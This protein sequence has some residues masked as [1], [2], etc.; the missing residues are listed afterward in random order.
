M[1][2]LYKKTGDN[3]IP[4]SKLE[5]ETTEFDKIMFTIS[6]GDGM[7]ESDGEYLIDLFGFK[8]EE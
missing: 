3:L 1:Q 5:K 2:D 6:R 7:M 4:D 8:H